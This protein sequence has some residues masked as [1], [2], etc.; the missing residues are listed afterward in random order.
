MRSGIDWVEVITPYG[1]IHGVAEGSN[2]HQW[3]LVG[4][5]VLKPESEITP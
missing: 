1:R 2:F 3:I 4:K 5:F